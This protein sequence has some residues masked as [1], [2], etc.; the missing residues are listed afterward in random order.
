M[1]GTG[2]AAEGGRPPSELRMRHPA[3]APRVIVITGA[4]S[5]IGHAT[6]LAFADRGEIVVLAARGR[7]GLDEVARECEARGAAT[8]VVPTDVSD[9]RQVQQLCEAAIARFGHVDV[10]IN[11]VG[12]GVV[13]VFD[14]TPIEAHHRVVEA[15]LIGHMNGAHAALGHFRSRGRGTL[16]NMISIAG[17]VSSPYAAAYSATKFALRGFSEALRAEM[18]ALPAVHVCEVYP[19]FVDTPGMVHG[20]NY[21]G[22]RIKPPPPLVDPRTVAATLV[23]LADSPRA[24]VMVGSIAVPGR[25]AHA[26]APDLVGR[27]TMWLMEAALARADATPVTDGN[28]HSPSVNTAVDGGYRARRTAP[29]AGAALAVGALALGWLASSRLRR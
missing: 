3:P 11:N 25:L 8:L 24:A 9:H 10:W 16:I 2:L 13:G 14:R 29:A 20:A 5:G 23:G 28:L 7:S 1:R 4:S 19:T 18:S 22:R 21:T 12:I 26:I 27:V 15:N 17:F 6:S